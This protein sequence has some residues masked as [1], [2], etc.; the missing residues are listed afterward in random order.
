MEI[1]H[2]QKDLEKRVKRL[3]KEMFGWKVD[4]PVHISNRMKRTLGQYAWK[5]DE[6]TQ[7]PELVKFQFASKLFTDGYTEEDIDDIIKHELIHWYTDVNE[8]KPCHHNDIWKANCRKF[9]VS[10]KR[11]VDLKVTGEDYR[12]KY[13]C[14][15]ASCGIVYKRYRRVPKGSICGKCRSKLIEYPLIKG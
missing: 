12:W 10:D 5:I 13:Q 4:K 2:I 14:S 3:A 6:E 9:G 15:K 7:R 1:A 11:L 8:G